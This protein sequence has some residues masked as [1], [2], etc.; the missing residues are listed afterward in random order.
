M[1]AVTTRVL[2]RFPKTAVVWWSSQPGKVRL[3]AG[4][5]LGCPKY[6]WATHDSPVWVMTLQEVISWAG[7]TLSARAAVGS[8]R[9]CALGWQSEGG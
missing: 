6:S 2:I 3:L 4:S 7:G 1:P 9:L 8:K 5:G